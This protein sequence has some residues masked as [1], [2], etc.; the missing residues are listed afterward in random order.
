MYELKFAKL[1][2]LCMIFQTLYELEIDPG[3]R[4]N[5]LFLQ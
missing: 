5:E 4:R 2:E 1:V 3:G